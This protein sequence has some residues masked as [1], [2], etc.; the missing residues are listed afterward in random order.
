M[1]EKILIRICLVS[2]IV[3]IVIMFFSTKLISPSVLKI[4]DIS[5]NQNYVKIH[6]KIIEKSISKS[7]TTFLKIKDDTGTIDG[8]IF[9]D[10]IKNNESIITGKIM[11]IVGKPEK[12]KEKMEIIISSIK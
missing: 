3:G 1:N 5:E 9:K 6:G 12:Y 11:E 10:S 4:E 2:V 8:V 7:G